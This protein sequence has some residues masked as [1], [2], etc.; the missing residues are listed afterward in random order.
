MGKTLL[1]LIVLVFGLGEVSF[2]QMKNIELDK[3]VVTPHSTEELNQRAVQDYIYQRDYN[4]IKE[5]LGVKNAVQ[6]MSITDNEKAGAEQAKED[7]EYNSSAV[8]KGMRG[9]GNMVT[10]WADIPET[11]NDVAKRHNIFIGATAGFFKGL[12]VAFAR[13]AGGLYDTLTFPLPP[14]NEAPSEPEYVAP[15]KDGIFTLARW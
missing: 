13:G 9:I 10:F 14:Y 8:N 6:E 12:V 7:A 3:I 1:L 11:M 15:V 5:Q 2:A 4:K